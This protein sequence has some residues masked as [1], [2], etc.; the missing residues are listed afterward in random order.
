MGGSLE[1]SVF[2][3]CF[4][5]DMDKVEVIFEGKKLYNKICMFNNVRGLR[6]VYWGILS[7]FLLIFVK[8]L[9]TVLDCIL[10]KLSLSLFFV[11]N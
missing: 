10:G 1:R 8:C 5:K 6:E 9:D 3:F 2:C 7:D 11:Y 4:G